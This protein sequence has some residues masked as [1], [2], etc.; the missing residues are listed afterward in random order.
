[1]ASLVDSWIIIKNVEGKIVTCPRC[2]RIKNQDMIQEDFLSYIFYCTDGCQCVYSVCKKCGSNI[3]KG[4][5]C[6]VCKK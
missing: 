5:T 4:N 6:T 2:H 1:M 3:V